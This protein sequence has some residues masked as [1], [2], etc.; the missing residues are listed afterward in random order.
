MKNYSSQVVKEYLKAGYVVLHPTKHGVLY[1]KPNKPIILIGPNI[2]NSKM[3]SR[4]I[5]DLKK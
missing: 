3:A 5:R 4:L 1:S 2:T